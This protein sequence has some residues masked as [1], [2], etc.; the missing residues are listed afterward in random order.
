MVRL[1]TSEEPPMDIHL[2]I[3][4]SLHMMA[5][6]DKFASQAEKQRL[7]QFVDTQIK[8]KKMLYLYDELTGH[9]KVAQQQGVAKNYI[10]SAF[11]QQKAPLF[12]F[13]EG[14][15][16]DLE[17]SVEKELQ[18]LRDA[19]KEAQESEGE[20]EVRQAKLNIANFY[21][22]IGNWEQAQKSYEQCISES[23]GVGPKLDLVFT[24]MRIAFFTLNVPVLRTL[25][26][27][28]NTLLEEGGDW[29]RRNR[30]R[31]YEGITFM[32]LRDFKRAAEAFL[33]SVST[34]S[35]TE[36]MSYEDFV[37]YTVSLSMLALDRPQ[38]NKKVLLNSDVLTV[39]GTLGP[40]EDY[41]R[42]FYNSKYQQF[43]LRLC[44]VL[45][46]MQTK[47]YMSRHIA[48]YSREMRILAYKQFLQ[49]YKSVTMQSMSQAFGLSMEFLDRELARFIAIHRLPCKIDKVRQVIETQRDDERSQK[50]AKTIKQGDHLLNRIQ[51]LSRVMDL[52]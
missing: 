3:A 28:A 51:K 31:I 10:S 48:F 15:Y 14:V 34:F 40:L 42:S 24:K 50:Y 39:I 16:R 20:S 26:E 33:S 35:A 41:L 46:M 32:L 1:T 52:E 17:V 44:D 37:F 23:V 38:L 4:D 6:S 2:Q 29:E 9:R 21:K 19:V 49:A 22:Q 13:D 25:I 30:L 12:N 18:R 43:L 47:R 5:L 8:E 45:D 7:K 27:R 11:A 36:L